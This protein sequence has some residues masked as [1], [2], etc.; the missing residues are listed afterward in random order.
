MPNS[1]NIPFSTTIIIPFDIGDNEASLIFENNVTKTVNLHEELRKH[2]FGISNNNKRKIIDN[3]KYHSYISN[4][5][6][7]NEK[8][9]N[10]LSFLETFFIDPEKVNEKIMDNI[11]FNFFF[12]RINLKLGKSNLNFGLTEPIVILNKLI[13]IGYIIFNFKFI[14][15]FDDFKITDA[16][17]KDTL[18]F[19]KDLSEI[20]F[21][22]FFNE[23][24]DKH[25]ISCTY[26][27]K[28]FFIPVESLIK[29]IFSKFPKTIFFTYLKPV[30]FH[31]GIFPIQ[32][33]EDEEYYNL[34]RI[35]PMDIKNIN[36]IQIDSTSVEGR[37]KFVCMNEGA[38]IGDCTTK[39]N[40]MNSIFNKYFPAFIIA[41][42]QREIMIKVSRIISE[43]P[44][45]EIEKN[46]LTFIEKLSELRK[47]IHILQLKQVFY[48]ISN[49]NEVACFYK[50][51]QIKFN[52]E[53]L[54]NDN[55]DSI[56]SIH[57]IL[58]SENSKKEKLRNQKIENFVL[59]IT[60]IGGFTTIIQI[61]EYF[62]LNHYI[63]KIIFL[64]IILLLAVIKRKWI[65]KLF[66]H[67]AKNQ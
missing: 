56:D 44:D 42:N 2:L 5:L 15:N 12:N 51:L 21:F 40:D 10:D 57:G 13:K 22:R 30:L 37:I 23:T 50:E 53:L 18:E 45:I 8:K 63:F 48:S 35:P 36:S 54:L 59:L 58:D 33:I 31:Y 3:F 16:S 14:K 27:N 47:L 9:D 20:D 43:I 29:G 28:N 17:D 32:E 60:I 24:R 52:L 7:S 25:C 67:K 65:F 64:L 11:P 6:G 1:I 41:L 38:M 62:G 34:L 26:E 4:Y 55:K 46:S 19:I 39:K 61:I 66:D 49:F